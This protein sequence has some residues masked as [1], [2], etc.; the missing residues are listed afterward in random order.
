[1]SRDPLHTVTLPILVDL[2]KSLSEADGW[3][4]IVSETATRIS[5]R[6][7]AVQVVR[8]ERDIEK[9]L[10]KIFSPKDISLF[11]G[12]ENLKAA[13]DAE[14]VLTLHRAIKQVSPWEPGPWKLGTDA[15]PNWI[16][17]HAIYQDD[18]REATGRAA[19][20]MVL[21]QRTTFLARH[22]LP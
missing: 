1:M 6:H 9:R 18:D 20:N 14:D 11:A 2:E 3:L 12:V 22:I 8:P 16:G 21:Q 4:N 5:D 19:S 13:Y 7:V 17:V 15:D 10:G